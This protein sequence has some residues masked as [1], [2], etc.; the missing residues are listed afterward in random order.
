MSFA[1]AE[2]RA[3]LACFSNRALAFDVRYVPL[4]G[5]EVITTAIFEEEEMVN[6][7]APVQVLET[8]T[9]ARLLVSK[10]KAPRRGDR[11]F[12]AVIGDELSL[13]QEGESLLFNDDGDRLVFPDDGEV[14]A[15]EDV[16]RRNSLEVTCVLGPT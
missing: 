5:D 12:L 6:G 3:T 1:D 13:S 4:V 2:R 7:D 9:L 15:V 16:R 10:V 8:R 14:Y 11:I